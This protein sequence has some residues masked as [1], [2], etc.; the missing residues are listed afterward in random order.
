MKVLVFFV[1]A[2]SIYTVVLVIRVWL[3]LGV[4]SRGTVLR[5]IEA[6]RKVKDQ[7]VTLTPEELCKGLSDGSPEAGLQSWLQLDPTAPRQEFVRIGLLADSVFQERAVRWL[8]SFRLL[9]SAL[10]LAVLLV[11]FVFLSD[12]ASILH[13]LHTS[14]RVTLS[15]VTFRLEELFR[16]LTGAT[17]LVIVAYVVHWHFASRLRARIRAWE[18]FQA[19]IRESKGL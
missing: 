16:A 14:S 5:L 3:S 9:Q 6:A 19:S 11:A 17:F 15:S 1:L 13:D 18:E 12:S 2:L 10:V 4:S 7:G 8:R